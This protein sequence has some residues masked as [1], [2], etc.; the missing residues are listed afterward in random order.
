MERDLQIMVVR[1][2]HA[3]VNRCCKFGQIDRTL[4]GVLHKGDIRLQTT[5]RGN[6]VLRNVSTPEQNS[7]TVLEG[8]CPGV[9]GFEKRGTNGFGYDPVFMY[10][11]KSFAE[12]EPEQKNAVSHRGAAFRKLYDYLKK[13]SAGGN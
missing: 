1:N 10:G 12:L 5:K 3:R 7:E 4:L 2:Q 9:I 8:D 13:L 11:E 6:L